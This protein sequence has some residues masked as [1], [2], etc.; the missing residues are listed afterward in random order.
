MTM[1]NITNIVKV[2]RDAEVDSALGVIVVVIIVVSV[3]A[4]L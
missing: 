3:N 4:D 1:L 2:A